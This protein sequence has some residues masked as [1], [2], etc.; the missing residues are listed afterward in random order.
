MLSLHFENS[1]K[2]IEIIESM[3]YKFERDPVVGII[4][5]FVLI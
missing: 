4:L 1:N 3:I 5:R 2:N